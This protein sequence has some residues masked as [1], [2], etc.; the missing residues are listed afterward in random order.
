ME[1]AEAGLRITVALCEFW[2]FPGVNGD[3]RVWLD[4]A[5]ARP[6]A[7]PRGRRLH[8]RVSVRSRLGR[9]IWLPS[10]TPTGKSR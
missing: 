10:T 4:R 7:S 9:T 5:L 1:A 2:F 3:G 6:R 8:D